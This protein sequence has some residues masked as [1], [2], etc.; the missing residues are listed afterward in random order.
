LLI[1]LVNAPDTQR[2]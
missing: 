1:T 2:V